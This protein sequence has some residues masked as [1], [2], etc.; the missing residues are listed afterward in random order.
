MF[1]V[2]S[3]KT[4]LTPVS[5]NGKLESILQGTTMVHQAFA[6]WSEIYH[7]TLCSVVTNVQNYLQ[8][9]WDLTQVATPATR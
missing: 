8:N 9:D 7:T 6:Y 4:S 2:A 1:A 5:A 3:L